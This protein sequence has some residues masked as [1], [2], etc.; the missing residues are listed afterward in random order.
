METFFN[1]GSITMAFHI[2][3]VL[4]ALGGH[5]KMGGVRNLGTDKSAKI[6]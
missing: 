2:L 4:G 1:K 6:Y 3:N 5:A